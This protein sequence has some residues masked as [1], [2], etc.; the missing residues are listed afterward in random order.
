ML[1]DFFAVGG[2]LF[3]LIGGFLLFL[4]LRQ[5]N[6]EAKVI[7]PLD[8]LDAKKLDST[9]EVR[10]QSALRPL[11]SKEGYS[12]EDIQQIFTKTALLSKGHHS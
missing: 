7:P 12:D 6:A 10:V 11:L 9:V 2:V 8:L 1:G 5:R 3:C 4:F